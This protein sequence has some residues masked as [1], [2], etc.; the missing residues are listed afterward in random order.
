M[1]VGDV[2]S[3][4]RGSGARFNEGKP[5]LEL[6][7][8]RVLVGAWARYDLD[9]AQ[10]AM[11]AALDRAARWQEGGHVAELY[12][13]LRELGNP[14][15][16]AARV[17]DY[18]RAKYAPFNWAKGMAWSVCV[19]CMARHA[20]AVLVVGEERDPESGLLH[21]GH[22]ACNLIFLITYHR[23]YPDGDDR[24]KVLAA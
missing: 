16:E 12:A 21:V 11:H 20:E 6:V 10:Q 24:P 18:G 13:A 7:P 5:P 19:G 3:A 15:R 23:I 22:F 1:N 14:F 2:T 9:D 17:L 8:L 4:A